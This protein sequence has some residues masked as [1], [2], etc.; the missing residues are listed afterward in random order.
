MK[1]T[2]KSLVLLGLLGTGASAWAFQYDYLSQSPYRYMNAEDYK[3]M[4]EAGQNLLDHGKDGAKQ[5]WI[6]H[7]TGSK[8]IIK[9]QM[10]YNHAGS[11]CRRTALVTQTAKGL[12]E[13]SVFNFC[14]IDGEWKVKTA[15]SEAFNDEDWEI[16]GKTAQQAL[17]HGKNGETKT[18]SNPKTGSSGSF[19]P[20]ASKA[21]DCRALYTSVEK[22]EYD[23]AETTLEVCK[24]ADGTWEQ[25]Q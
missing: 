11:V 19:K 20:L 1:T 6:N 24:K 17:D 9:V 25:R 14:K 3:I 8:G 22:A 23:K 12:S 7:D 4:L 13:K 16:F 2:I 10:T 5:N 15:P 21:A 18:W